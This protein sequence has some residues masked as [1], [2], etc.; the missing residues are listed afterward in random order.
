[1]CASSFTS[2]GT[3]LLEPPIARSTATGK[4]EVPLEPQDVPSQ[5]LCTSWQ[6]VV[7]VIKER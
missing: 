2:S 3:L 1:M 6:H 4:L 5:M 7:L